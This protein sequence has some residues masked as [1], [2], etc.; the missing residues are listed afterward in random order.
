MPNISNITLSE[1]EMQRISEVTPNEAHQGLISDTAAVL[2]DV[3]TDYE[4]ETVGVP[5]LS[6]VNKEVIYIP[7]KILPDMKENPKFRE[8]LLVKVA[9]KSNPV[10][11][12]CRSGGRSY[13]AACVAAKMGYE[14]CINVIGGFEGSTNMQGWKYSN[15]PWSR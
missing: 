11:F 5:D 1:E 10:Y 4:W 3:R 15:L 14:N 8:E 2:V 12:I 6:E 7:W 9:D 13:E